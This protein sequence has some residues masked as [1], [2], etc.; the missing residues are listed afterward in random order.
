VKK[1][2]GLSLI[3][4]LLLVAC[5]GTGSESADEEADGQEVAQ[6]AESADDAAESEAD[7]SEEKA[8]EEAPPATATQPPAAE[9]SES[10]P[11]QADQAAEEAPQ[12]STGPADCQLDPLNFGKN[13][14]IAEANEEDWQHGG[15]LDAKINLVEYGDFQ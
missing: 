3:L 11:T 13:P 14:A 5:G 7:Q 10:T 4:I 2:L 8:V 1:V 6:V 9:E 15:G 12:V